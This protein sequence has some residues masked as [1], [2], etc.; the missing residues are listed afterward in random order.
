MVR[1]VRD[2]QVELG[3]QIQA[4]RVEADL[5]QAEL[6][7]I[8]STSVSSISRLEAG[9][10]IALSTFVAVVRTLGREDWL[11]QLDP[12]GIGPSPMELLRQQ[13]GLSPRPKRVG[14]RR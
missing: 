6:A 8:V 2:I 13:R 12:V 5:S 4:L 11:G 1:T 10:T 3:R 7:D 14:R 9:R